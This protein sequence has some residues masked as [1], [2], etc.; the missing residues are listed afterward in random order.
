MAS[1]GYNELIFSLNNLVEI[2]PSHTNTALAWDYDRCYVIN[3]LYG[4]LFQIF[5]DLPWLLK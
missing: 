3:T 2:V 5:Y 4:E 1:L